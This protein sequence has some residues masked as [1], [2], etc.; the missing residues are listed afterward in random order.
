MSKSKVGPEA[1]IITLFAALSD[2]SKRIVLDVI[3][4]QSPIPRKATK[5][6]EKPSASPQAQKELPV[7]K[8]PLCGVCGNPQDYQDHFKPSP[9]YHEF[10]P[11][12]SVAR[13]GRKSKQNPV[14]I[15]SSDTGSD[16]NGLAA[17]MES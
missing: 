9:N 3:K 10:D 8:E 2:D 12:K 17:E 6:A 1:K 7:I 4:N 11:P 13:A 14:V 16:S 15:P 5:K